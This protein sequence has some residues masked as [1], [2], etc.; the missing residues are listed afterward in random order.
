M[1]AIWSRLFGGSTRHGKETDGEVGQ[2]VQNCKAQVRRPRGRSRTKTPPLEKA[3][4]G[5]QPQDPQVLL[6]NCAQD[7]VTGAMGG[8]QRGRRNSSDSSCLLAPSLEYRGM[9]GARQR[10][11]SN[12]SGEILDAADAPAITA[13]TYAAV[14]GDTI[15]FH[16]SSGGENVV[17]TGTFDNWQ[18]TVK[19]AR[20]PGSGNFYSATAP[21]DRSQKWLFKFVV[22]G[23]WRCSPHYPI[24]IDEQGNENNVYYP[25]GRNHLQ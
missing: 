13:A 24:E 23:M 5:S 6:D 9:R 25:S 10:S 7:N 14:P 22:D 17:V 2:A 4:A 19:L 1:G 3:Y 8:Y 18:Q 20:M 21:L 16:W 15:E 12:S 11:G